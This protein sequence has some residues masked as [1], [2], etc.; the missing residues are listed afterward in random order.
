VLEHVGGLNHV[1]VDADQDH[2]L[3]V[4]RSLLCSSCS[5]SSPRSGWPDDD[6]VLIV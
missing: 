5:C 6:G 3:E 4:H 2:V 1:V